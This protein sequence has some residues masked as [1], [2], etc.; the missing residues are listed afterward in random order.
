MATMTP[1]MR[2]P[3]LRLIFSKLQYA[4][5]SLRNPDRSFKDFYIDRIQDVLLEG[6]EHPSLGTRIKTSKQG[7]PPKTFQKLLAMGIRPHDTVVD[8]GCGTLRIGAL[9]ID[10]LDPDRY[11]GMDIDK[12]IITSALKQLP[13]DLLNTKRPILE[14][15][16]PESLHR[17][18][19]R[20]PRW[21]FAK[22]V[23]QHIPPREVDEFLR[24]FCYLVRDGGGT[25][26]IFSRKGEAGKVSCMTWIHDQAQLEVFAKLHGVR[27]F[28]HK[29]IVTLDT[30]TVR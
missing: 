4:F 19:E 27:T 7:R 5:W 20:R 11:V 29:G 8:Y 3:N 23:L 22:G 6:R 25:G 1:F 9:L 17:V 14:V 26:L 15:I 10:Y 13:R 24:N 28:R 18:A 30:P 16:S 12:S 21:I 2:R